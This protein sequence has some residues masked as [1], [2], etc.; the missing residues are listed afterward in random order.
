MLYHGAMTIWQNLMPS[1]ALAPGEVMEISWR[2]EDL[3]LYRTAAGACGAITAYCPHMGN[4]IPN[5]LAPGKPLA[6]L[7][8]R[9]ELRCPYHGWRFNG[10]GQ[11]THI[12]Q[13]Q[14]VPASVR[15]GRAIARSWRVRE[16]ARQIQIAA[17]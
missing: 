16:Q 7:L 13:S 4:Y 8:A 15:R 11:C 14:A 9:D 3:L 2:G 12:P 1:A 6:A 5:G 17:R 10:Q